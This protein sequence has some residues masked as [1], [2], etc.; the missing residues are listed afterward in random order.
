MW[1]AAI[2]AGGRARRYGG[3]D[4]STLVVDGHTIRERQLAALSEVGLP[5]VT[6]AAEHTQTTPSDDAIV[7]DLEPAAG[8]MGAL[9]TALT[10]TSADRVLALAAD[11]PFVTP[12]FLRWLTLTGEAADIV[13]PRT[14]WG[15]EPL[16]ATY[17]R[18]CTPRLH[19]S[20][21]RGK[22]SLHRFI[23][24][25]RDE[26]Q[27]VEPDEVDLAPFGPCERL[28]LNVNTPADY[29]RALELVG[30]VSGGTRARPAPHTAVC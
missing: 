3:R 15:L 22:L 25:N 29:A 5:V 28:F 6:V 18:A 24:T 20:L 16:C 14:R 26:L 1:T 8:P 17:S 27:V 30:G 12:A 11:M 9:W 19:D 2:L 21:R 23:A 7:M 13:V 4:K 10:L